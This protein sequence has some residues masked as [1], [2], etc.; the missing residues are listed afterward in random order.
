V[1]MPADANPAPIPPGARLDAFTDDE[2]LP[3]FEANLDLPHITAGAGDAPGT[4]QAE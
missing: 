1:Q 2:V 3:V 4:Q